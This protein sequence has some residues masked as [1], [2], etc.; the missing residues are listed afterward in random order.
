MSN[1]EVVR[2]LKCFVARKLHIAI[3]RTRLPVTTPNSNY[4]RHNKRKKWLDGNRDITSGEA[5]PLAVACPR[6]ADQHGYTLPAPGNHPL[7]TRSGA[8]TT[9]FCLLLASY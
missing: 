2:H 7:S 5:G 9:V 1:N 6:Q 3:R 8:L 4:V